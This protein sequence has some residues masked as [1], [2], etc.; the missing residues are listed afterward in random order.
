MKKGLKMGCRNCTKLAEQLEEG[1]EQYE[2]LILENNR[3]WKEICQLE[4]KLNIGEEE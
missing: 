3:L 2:D 4:A 1:R